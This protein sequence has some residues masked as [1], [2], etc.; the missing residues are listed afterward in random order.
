MRKYR[1]PLCHAL[2]FSS[3]SRNFIE[4]LSHNFL[5]NSNFFKDIP[6]FLLDFFNKTWLHLWKIPYLSY[7]FPKK[8]IQNMTLIYKRMKINWPFNPPNNFTK[9]LN[10]DNIKKAKYESLRW[11][12]KWGPNYGKFI[13]EI[14][15]G[16]QKQPCSHPTETNFN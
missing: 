7:L 10:F 11:K 9:M 6:Q 8:R 14:S 5:V 12:W 2:R 16:Y 13:L 4:N 1:T 3:F 15:G